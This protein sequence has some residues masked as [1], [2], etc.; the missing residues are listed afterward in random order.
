MHRE[1]SEGRHKQG[2]HR[3]S[4]DESEYQRF[5]SK[6]DFTR[7]C[8]DVDGESHSQVVSPLLLGQDLTRIPHRPHRVFSRTETWLRNEVI[9]RVYIMYYNY[10]TRYSK[11]HLLL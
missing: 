9:V 1:T 11:H 8:L 3:E 7:A 5:R 2:M 6:S 10:H 4:R